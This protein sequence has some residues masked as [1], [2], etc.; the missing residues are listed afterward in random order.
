MKFFII[1]FLSCLLMACSS[2]NHQKDQTD[3]VLKESADPS[4][5]QHARD[6]AP[7]KRLDP[8]HIEDAKPRL[9]PVRAAGNKS[10]YMVFGKVYHVM[11]SSKNY[12]EQGKASWYGLKFHGH[13]TSNGEVYDIQGM[14]AAHKTLPLPSYVKVTNVANGRSAIVRVNDR[15]PFHDERIIDLS[16]AAATKLGY[17]D[18]GTAEVLVEAID[19]EQWL[20]Q[21]RQG[22][23]YVVKRE[24]ASA[25]QNQ[26]W[27]QI[28]AYSNEATAVSVQKQL[29][30]HF[31]W[32]TVVDRGGDGFH[33]V[34]MGPVPKQEVAYVSQQLVERGF[35]LPLKTKP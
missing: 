22:P 35:P 8:N 34:K 3:P 30:E 24:P 32:S 13:N 20:A 10:P 33:R 28:G 18:Q 26:I 29:L 11:E 9:D 19:V 31:A 5:Y 27:L 6:F 16:Y 14:T 17:I 15:G 21:T 1:T 12:K 7:L 2:V 4:R 25:K 23:G